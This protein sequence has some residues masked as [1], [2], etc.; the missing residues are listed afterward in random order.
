MNSMT[1]YNEIINIQ[2]DKLSRNISWWPIYLYHFTD[3][4]NAVSI[5]EKEYILGRKLAKEKTL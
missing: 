1:T 2:R 5:I 3:I 4:H